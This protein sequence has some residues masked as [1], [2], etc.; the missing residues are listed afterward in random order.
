M[1]RIK[2]M[3]PGSAKPS[4]KIG[5]VNSLQELHLLYILS[6]LKER[7]LDEKRVQTS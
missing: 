7:R 4:L 1:E 3:K 6:F 5:S 2:K